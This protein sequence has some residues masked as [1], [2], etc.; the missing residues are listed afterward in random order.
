MKKQRAM[1]ETRIR[2]SLASTVAPLNKAVAPVVRDRLGASPG[3]GSSG[4]VLALQKSVG[5]RAV[6]RLVERQDAPP[7]PVIRRLPTVALRQNHPA[8]SGPRSRAVIELQQRALGNAAVQFGQ[9]GLVRE[10][11]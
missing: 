8:T 9:K 1:R 11:V 2:S 4:E 3:V 6:S 5:N 7:Q 10:V